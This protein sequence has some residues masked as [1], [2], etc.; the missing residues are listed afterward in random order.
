MKMAELDTDLDPEL[1]DILSSLEE[2]PKAAPKALP[3]EDD[4][5]PPELPEEAPSP[6]AVPAQRL[7]SHFNDDDDD[8]APLDPEAIM[9][10]M[11]TT[12]EPQITDIFKAWMHYH[13]FIVVDSIGQLEEVVAQAFKTGK[14]SL[15][16]E[17]QG[18]DNRIYKRD[19]S[20]IRGPYEEYWDGPQ[21]ERIL[22][23]VHKIVG[24]CLSPDGHTGYYVP[25]RHTGEGA[26]KNLDVVAVGRV[27][28]KLCLASQ[29]VIKEEGRSVDPLASPLIEKPRVKL[30]FWHA[31]FD[32]EFLLPVTGIDFWHPESFEDGMLVYYCIYTND[33]NLGLK[34]KSHKKL[35][36]QRNGNPVLGHI[37]KDP[38]NPQHEIVEESP[39]GVPIP[40]EM[41]ELKDLFLRGRP[42]DFGSLDPYEARFY[43]C[44]DA[45]CT[46]LH[47]DH[48]TIQSA[49]KD[50]KF[51]GMYR[52][53]KQVVQV[54]R[55][56]ERNRIKIDRDYVRQLFTDARK[57]A[58]EY[59]SQIVALA[60]QK[61]F[62]N[63][64]PQSTQQLSEFLFA[65]PNG[66]NI[67]PKPD[68]TKDELRNQYKTDADTLEKLVEEHPDINPILLTI[69]KFRQVEKV[70]GTYLEGMLHNCDENSE[71]RYQ[72]KQTGAPTGRFTAPAGQAEH[73][74]GA[75]PIHGIPSTYDEKKP[76]VATAL[77]KAFV[78]R[79]GY[80]MVKVDFAGEELRIV[81]NL[82]GEPVWIKEFNEGSGDLHTITAKAFF[83]D[84]ITKQQRQMGKCV[85]PDT[86]VV[87]GG[88]YL[89]IRLLGDF[90]SQGKFT[91][92][93]GLLF[94]GTRDQPVTSLYNGG[95]KELFH[96]VVSGGILTCSGDHRLK[97]R[98]GDWIKVK[99]LEGGTLLEECPVQPLRSGQYPTLSF[100][101]WNGLPPQQFT[102]NHHLAYFA[103]LY[104]G[105]GRGTKSCVSL[106]HGE[107][108]KLDHYGVD[109]EEWR[110]HLEESLQVCGFSTSRK[111][112]ASIYFG[113]TVVAKFLTELGIHRK[114]TKSL[115]VPHWV[116]TAGREAALHYLGGIFDTDGTVG[117]DGHN[118][119]WTS[120]DFVF[121]GQIS[122]LLKA[123]GLSF[124]TELTFNTTYQRYYA[125]LCLTVG[126]SWAIRD[127][128]R[129]PGKR[130]RL[131][132]PMQN[133]KIKDRFQVV[134]VLPAG[135]WPCLDVTMGTDQHQYQA[136][137]FISHNSANF[138]LVY[139][140]GAMAIMRATKC[141]QQEAARRKAN[142]DK[143]MPVFNEWVKGQKAKVKR[144]KGVYSA[145]GR[146]MA[147]PDIDSPDKAVVAACERYSLNY[148]IQACLQG[149]SL[150]LTERG[151]SKISDLVG[152]TFRVWTG[153]KWAQASARLMGR[154]QLAE[155]TLSDGTIVR[156][157]T[158]H[159]QL[160][161]TDEGYNWVE[162]N[163]LKSGMQVATSLCHPV[164]F[165]EV[166]MPRIGKRSYR[167]RLSP[168]LGDVGSLW[169]WMGR[170]LGDG[171]FDSRGAI[172]YTF[173]WHEYTSVQKCKEFWRTFGLNPKV[174]RHYR[175]LGGGTN[176]KVVYTV[177]VWSVDLTD[178]LYHIGFGQGCT[179]H[180]K[181]LPPR[182]LQET[183]ENRKAFIRG[184]MDS[185]GHKPS[186][187]SARGNPYNIHL[188]QRPLLE[189]LKLLL[190]TLGVESVIRGPY[191]SGY[192]KNGD[193]TTSYRLDLNRRMFERNVQGVTTRGPKF[194]DMFAPDFQVQDFLSRG[195]WKPSNF[196]DNSSYVLYRR[197]I[198]GG[199]V[200]VY[201]LD[202]LCKQVGVTL[203]NPIY[204]HKKIKKIKILDQVEETYT[205]SVKDPLHR[206]EADGVITKNSGADIMKMSMVMLYKEFSKQGWIQGDD[207][208]A[209]FMLTV[210]DE[211]VFEVKHEMLMEVMPV[212]E[213]IMT[214]PGRMK[215]WRVQL[216]VEPLIDAHW[217]P[218]YDYHK[219]MKG[220]IPEAGKK[221]KDSDI[222]F[223]D[224]YYQ[225]PPPWLEGILVPD[226]MRMGAK[227]DEPSSAPPA[228]DPPSPEPPTQ[229]SPPPEVKK[230]DPPSPTEAK[231][232]APKPSAPPSRASSPPT[233]GKSVPP[234]N[235]KSGE[236][237]RVYLRSWN[238]TRRSIREVA[239]FCQA[240][241]DVN[242]QVLHLIDSESGETL[243]SPD[244]KVLVNAKLF[245]DEM[246]RYNLG[247]S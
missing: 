113:S 50:K 143:A 69:V 147:V 31:K 51:A 79:A 63:F 140:G 19:P 117:R 178:W 234:T 165:P 15:D 43:A 44:S 173:G 220:Y 108:G 177:E 244:L 166:P 240:C 205:L 153:D 243:I 204:G 197:L 38:K 47:C 152:K 151:Y 111:D 55:W 101:L 128:I 91:D 16:L 56:M 11:G 120:K 182:I 103:G 81:T 94:D 99:D 237:L 86:L 41:I 223:G 162:F 192:D 246:E 67:E 186:L 201:S 36:V 25:V 146:W 200:T 235:G 75:I 123:C 174:R 87:S 150:V 71:L 190:R 130:S 125:R 74:Y 23:T 229:S 161:V 53:E 135:T 138:S 92:W 155:I 97:S 110:A 109:Y 144:E 39:T 222:K 72:F 132:A 84:T 247:A 105:D 131:R 193:S 199:K 20:R 170:Y 203:R 134:K 90:S 196:R 46:F 189:D 148:P 88:E 52:I 214:E 116:L 157:D 95:E 126:S 231:S 3:V 1:G 159:K 2:A 245:V 230:A 133:A 68:K 112:F 129:H 73:G 106:T 215:K 121:A 175:K 242:G 127:Y 42:I 195:D 209:R 227:P 122:V 28:K 158:K 54:L 184:V 93:N 187:V 14:C 198:N 96:V 49:I 13:E 213:R 168:R 202:D 7:T 100:S 83:G 114:T 236:P 216:E 48:P 66:L 141:T 228:G 10:S 226:Y 64:D 70:I 82:S 208:K 179:A 180:T 26:E 60:E 35:S 139:G 185:D 149:S 115:R 221:P 119:D 62:R 80:T 136:N 124:N 30:F 21:P 172:I 45:I 224:R 142:F 194:Y 211:I 6:P 219:I 8:E 210:H 218:K 171:W 61:G 181:R 233:N 176:A 12:V 77:R 232:E 34:D 225:K 238:L 9:E 188:C 167:S 163:D 57:E 164:D 85:H 145:F 24:Y 239:G 22:Q 212:I 5:T 89:P 98:N 33:K 183:L 241:F 207:P 137:G 156:C 118:L 191:Q 17:T 102:P 160:W 40:Y 76:K 58:D 37:K 65:S 154:H 206:F 32:Q 29:P 18:L 59:R 27:I 169:Y 217:D 104:A 78:A 4:D 107:P